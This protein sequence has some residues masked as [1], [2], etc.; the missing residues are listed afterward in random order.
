ME[1]GD[2]QRVLGKLEEG[3]K[4]ITRIQE[5]QNETNRVLAQTLQNFSEKIQEIQQK[6]NSEDARFQSEIV[7]RLTNVEGLAQ[8]VEGQG[9]AILDLETR[10]SAQEEKEDLR[11]KIKKRDINWIKVIVVCV[12]ILVGDKFT[13]GKLSEWVSLL[14][15]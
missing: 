5:Q 4:Q 11:V 14:F 12:F 3:F 9:Q 2:V 8:Q 15:K 7:V 13:G 10:I 6:H 1:D